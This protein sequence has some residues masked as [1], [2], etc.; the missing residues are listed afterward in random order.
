MHLLHQ[1]MYPRA[2]G[3]IRD[4]FRT[5]PDFFCHMGSFC[6][7]TNSGF[8][9][10]TNSYAG[11]HQ[12]PLPVITFRTRA[13]SSPIVWTWVVKDVCSGHWAYAGTPSCCYG[14][15]QQ[16]LLL[17]YISD[18]SH[19]FMQHRDIGTLPNFPQ[20]YPN[21][22]P[23]KNFLHCFN[24]FHISPTSH[25]PHSSFLSFRLMSHASPC[26]PPMGV[27]ASVLLLWRNSLW[28]ATLSRTWYFLLTEWK[29]LWHTHRHYR[30][31][32]CSLQEWYTTV[33]HAQK[34]VPFS[35]QEPNQSAVPVRNQKN[36]TSHQLA[37]GKQAWVL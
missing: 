10:L 13:C 23:I 20:L 22:P 9:C 31:L 35:F 24:F 33:W 8:C 14:Q 6:C 30:A 3:N 17:L 36:I 29:A 37:W 7:P 15:K 34:D 2:S 27:L 5:I 1:I 25:F 26:P 4:D 16:V 19:T 18:S 12:E 11:S 21:F 32:H 28:Y